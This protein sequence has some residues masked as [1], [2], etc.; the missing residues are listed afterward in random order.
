MAALTS[1]LTATVI[2]MSAVPLRANTRFLIKHATRMLPGTAARVHL[3]FDISTLKPVEADTLQKNE[4][5]TADFELFTPI[6]CDKYEN[7]RAAGS[8]IVIDPVT[9][10]TVAAAMITGSGECASR[11]RSWPGPAPENGLAVWFTGL[12][13][14]GKTTLCN[15]VQMK[16]LA[17]G[18]PVETIDGDMMRKH[19]SKDLGFSREDRNEN[20]SR[21]ALL[22][23]LLSRNGNIVLVSAISPYRAARDAARQTLGS[24]VEVYV[25]AP[26]Q[27][28]EARDTKGLY[29]NA[30]AGVIRKFTGIDDPYEPPLNPEI[31]CDTENESVRESTAKV[32]EY[33]QRYLAARHAGVSGLSGSLLE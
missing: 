30:R 12:S 19:L 17:L 11:D 21:M 32:V 23:H 33:V 4:I 22:A 13:G 14:A 3:K 2:W 1:H 5:G 25:S 6:F 10:N 8:F 20:I 9:K 28:C 7:D 24:F 26:L 15:T 27:I 31:V 29:K 18:L 16:L